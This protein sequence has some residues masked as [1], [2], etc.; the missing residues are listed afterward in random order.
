MDA[1]PNLATAERQTQSLD[2]TWDFRHESDSAWRETQVPSPWQSFPDLA[3][4]FG[5]ATYRRHFSIPADW[6]DRELALHFGA[7][8]DTAT[9]RVNG[10]E[11]ARHEGGYLPFEVVLPADLLEEDNLLEVE[12]YLPDAHH[13]ESDFAEIPH[14]KQSWYGP[15]GGIWQSVHLKARSPPTTSPRSASTRTGPRAASNSA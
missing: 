9:V 7:V 13:A 10:Q 1:S 4:S 5:R 6:R 14:G 3:W 8:S 15:Q 11:V 2:G 12:A